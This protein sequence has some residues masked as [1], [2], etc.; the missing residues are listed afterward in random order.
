MIKIGGGISR[1]LNSVSTQNQR[2]HQL[3][4]YTRESAF[5]FGTRTCI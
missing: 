4:Q 2:R 1:G 3:L 5:L